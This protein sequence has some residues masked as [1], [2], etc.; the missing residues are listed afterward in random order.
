VDPNA[1]KL[2][3]DT[4]DGKPASTLNNVSVYLEYH[5]DFAGTILWNSY[6]KR[7]EIKGGVLEQFAK[8]G[9]EAIVT[10]TQNYLAHAHKIA[11]GSYSD[12]SRRIMLVAKKNSYNPLIYYLDSLQW[13]SK[14]RI[15]DLFITYFGAGKISGQEPT[16]EE[17][18]LLAH[19]RRIGR[20]WLLGAVE[21]AYRPGCKVDNVLILEG[22]QGQK[23]SSALWALGGDFYCTTQ[24]TLGD[25]DSK[26]VAAGNWFVDM[27]DTNFMKTKNKG[28]ITM[29][30][31]T[32]RPPFGAAV[33]HTPRCCIFIGSINPDGE[34]YFEDITGNRRY[35]PIRCTFVDIV[36]LMRDRDQI[37]AEAVAIMKASET[38]EACLRSTDTV[39]GQRPRCA[40][41]RWWLDDA[42]EVVAAKIADERLAEVPWKMRVHQWWLNMEPSK[43]PPYFTV[44]TVAVEAL[45]M[46]EAAFSRGG[47]S[48]ESAV[49]AAVR[50]LGFWKDRVTMSGVRHWVYK[51]S[52]ELID[53]PQVKKTSRAVSA[54]EVFTGGKK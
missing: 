46:D 1:W 54:F 4:E 15:D 42:A 32:F 51:P 17:S 39:P 2:L 6:A 34:G 7:L 12:I 9:P 44:E 26:M 30:S 36:A 31:D 53:A 40:Q 5:P 37:W 28:F 24:I 41:H 27:P 35:W 20:C 11:V 25:K 18:E 33:E 43:R 50:S 3:L 49:G 21:R 14:S 8:C 23:K 38:C 16:P 45:D 13:D 47:R 19:L 48:L 22:R 52:F 10:G 29:Q